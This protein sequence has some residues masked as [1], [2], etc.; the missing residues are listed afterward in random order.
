MNLYEYF[1]SSCS[2]RLRI[3]LNIKGIKAEHFQINLLD[4][5]QKTDEYKAINPQ[6][7]VPTLIDGDI[8]IH[9]SLAALEYLEETH[10]TPP[11]LPKN[12]DARAKVRSIALAISC[13]IQPLNNIG[14]LSYLKD[15]MGLSDEQKMQWYKHWIDKGLTSIESMLNDS[16]QYCYQDYVTMADICLI[17]Q[18]YNALRFE[19]DT[20]NF[21]KII[22][23]YNECL[24]LPAFDE[25]QPKE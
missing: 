20:S 6:G 17:P 22:S 24:K 2:Y 7:T 18:V 16:G 9:Q 4:G 15:E 1:R 19:C 13:N 21:P 25:A 12:A 5:E 3:A 23:I 10:P 8:A 14:V 11:L